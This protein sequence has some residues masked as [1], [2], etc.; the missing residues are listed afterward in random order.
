MILDTIDNAHFYAGLMP[1]GIGLAL[2]ALRDRRFAASPPGRYAIQ[3]DDVYA[4]V[5]SYNTKPHDAGRWEAH[6][7]YIDV[8]FVLDGVE[9]MGVGAVAGMTVS[10]PYDP[11]RDVGFFKGAGD[12]FTLR[13]GMFAILLPHD[14]HMPGLMAGPV[15]PVT[16]IVVKVALVTAP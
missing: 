4:M 14:A 10:E 13:A 11:K 2:D 8:Q 3:G 16:K 5:Q 9:T 15:S 6:R 12:L 1:R 7:R